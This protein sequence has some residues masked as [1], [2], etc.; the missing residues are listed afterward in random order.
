MPR[1]SAR[2]GLV[3]IAIVA[4]LGHVC[5]PVVGHADPVIAHTE[6]HHH[7]HDG[8]DGDILHAASCE[9]LRPPVVQAPLVTQ[10]MAAP[11][12]EIVPVRTTASKTE[13]FVIATSPPPL[14]LLHAALLI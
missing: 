3:A 9:A 7:D 14:Y 11:R 8:H 6:S 4:I 5:A 10:L 2:L 13:L 12:I 1:R